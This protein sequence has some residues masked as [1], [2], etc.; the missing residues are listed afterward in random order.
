[1]QEHLSRD[2]KKAEANPFM[3]HMATPSIFPFP[4]LEFDDDDRAL[5]ES[6]ELLLLLRKLKRLPQVVAAMGV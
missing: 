2:T 4:Q 5:V 3:I 1:M 6:S